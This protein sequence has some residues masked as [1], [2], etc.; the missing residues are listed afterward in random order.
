M[1]I[2]I[3]G[4]GGVGGYYGGR[5]AL[6][7]QEVT[8]IAR[9]AHL[10][11]IRKNGLQV[12]SVH[13]DFTVHPARATE[14]PSEAGS[15]DLV[16]VCTKTYSTEAATRLLQPIVGPQT[17]VVSLQ[18]G[19][20]AAERIGDMI[21]MEHMLGGAT[22][23]SAAVEAPGVIRQFSQVHRVVVGELD[24]RITPRLQAI[25]EAFQPTG[26]T[27]EMTED[28]AKILWTKFLF[29]AA[30]SGMGSLTRLELGDFRHVP[31]TRRLATGLMREVE[32]VAHARGVALD[33]DVVEQTLAFLDGNAPHIKPSMQRDVEAGN[34]FELEAIIGVIGRKG[35][36]SGVP[37]PIAE[38][39]YAALLPILVKAEM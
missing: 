35:R 7:G 20:D 38:M 26:V 25:A 6:H 19:I 18:N 21:G 8:F 13:G 23:L 36:E 5:L 14:D 39:V 4:T 34:P 33:A 37:T 32:A 10:E 3:L 28:I 22:W 30:V 16:L 29:I 1:K 24:R 15:A 31:E 12:K 17:M 2:V 27:F 9:G 11:A